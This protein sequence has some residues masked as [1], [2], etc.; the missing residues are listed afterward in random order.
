MSRDDM[1]DEQPVKPKLSPDTIE[2]DINDIPIP[3]SVNG[4]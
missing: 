2:A 4:D 3:D 1:W